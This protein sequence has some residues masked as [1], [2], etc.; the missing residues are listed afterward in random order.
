MESIE[1]IFKALVLGTHDYLKKNGFSKA[2]IGLSGGIDS[3]LTAAIAVKAIGSEN[4]VGITMPS[5]Y[6]SQ[7]SID[8]SEALAKN[9][10]M[11]VISL[12][13]KEAML[14]YEKI[15]SKIFKNLPSDTTEEN[16][17]AR[18]RGNLMMALSNKMGWLVL[19]TAVSYTHLTLPT[20]LLV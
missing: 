18:I 17:Q 7:G 2:A 20:I 3:A 16:L 15:L 12:P 8:D 4:V 6:S 9:L 13:I 10:G 5:K 19:T 14:A 11:R 1:E